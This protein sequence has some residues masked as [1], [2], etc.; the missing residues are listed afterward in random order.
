MFGKKETRDTRTI[1]GEAVAELIEPALV[2]QALKFYDSP[3]Q[4][5]EAVAE[6]FEPP[7][8][9]DGVEPSEGALASEVF[10]YL[11][12]AHARLRIIDW[13]TGVIGIL[14]TLD[15]MFA[16]IGVAPVSVEQRAELTARFENAERGKAF[17]EMWKTM[18]SLAAERGRVFVYY[19]P[20][21]DAHGV[22]LPTPEAYERWKN[23]RFAKGYDVLS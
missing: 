18:E 8:I 12:E 5:V 11:L 16:A 23:V 22:M 3:E 15:E 6:E 21:G 20:E 4:F 7:W 10:V 13:A 17:L 19:N 14:D 9:E 2:P 1:L